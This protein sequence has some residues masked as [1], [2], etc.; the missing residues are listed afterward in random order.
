MTL[1]GM[2]GVVVL[3]IIS[4]AIGYAEGRHIGWSKGYNNG[5]E[6]GIKRS[7]DD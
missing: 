7:E 6:D 4:W 5:W 2:I 3:I 1:G